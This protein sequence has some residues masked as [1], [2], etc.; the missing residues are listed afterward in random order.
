MTNLG[1]GKRHDD[2]RNQN[3]ER[4]RI[5]ISLRKYSIICSWCKKVMGYGPVENS[6]ERCDGCLDKTLQK[7]DK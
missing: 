6:Y 5:A 2:M 3:R 1:L 4:N 7:I